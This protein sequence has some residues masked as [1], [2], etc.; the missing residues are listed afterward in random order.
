MWDFKFTRS[1]LKE[2][3]ETLPVVRKNC[4]IQGCE[5][6]G[7]YRAPK[8]RYELRDYYW[9]CLEHVRL[10]NQSWDFFKGMSGP[11][12]ESHMHRACVWDRPTWRMTQA[13]FNEEKTRQKIYEAFTKGESVFGDFGARTQEDAPKEKAHI[14]VSSI[15]HPAVEALQV[16]DLFP[17]IEWDEVKARYKTLVKKYHPDTNKGDK[18]AE[19]RLKK[20]NLAYSILKL[21]WQHY[22]TLD[23]K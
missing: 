14:D 23:E 10:Y 20:I 4:D 13:G 11:E 19:E 9:F 18:Q 12:I 2:H 21:S 8:S 7:E 16:M 17:P 5:H 6:L 15:P 1:F 22:T 3:E